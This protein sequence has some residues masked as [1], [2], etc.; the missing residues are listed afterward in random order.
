MIIPF[1]Y[2]N[3]LAWYG[4]RLAMDIFK[5]AGKPYGIELQG[6]PTSQVLPAGSSPVF[7]LSILTD[8]EYFRIFSILER[9]RIPR[10]S[11]NRD[12][13]HPV[14]VAGGAAMFQPEPLAD[15]LDVI[16]VGD[17]EEFLAGMPEI[18]SRK[19]PRPELIQ[20]LSELPGAYVPARRK[21]IYDDT[22]FFVKDMLGETAPIMG[23]TTRQWLTAPGFAKGKQHE[24]EIARGCN[25][26]CAFCAITWRNEFRER[27][28][29][30]TLKVLDGEPMD[31]F[32]P[33]TG[34]VS[35]FA[36]LL[37]LRGKGSKG[38]ITVTDFLTMPDPEP[39]AYK[40]DRYTF[41]IEGISHRL[42]RLIGKPITAEQIEEMVRRMIVG[43]AGHQQLYFIRGIPGES[44][45]DWDEL[46]NWLY[47]HAPIWRDV[48]LPTELQFTPLT[49]QAHTPL[50]YFAHP[51]NIWVEARVIKLVD[52]ARKT[53]KADPASNVYITAS[54]RATSWARDC[55]TNCTGRNGA[56]L[57]WAMHKGAFNK[58][59][60]DSYPGAG[61]TEF[62]AIVRE[63]GIDADVIFGDWPL[64]A[65]LPWSH[66][67]P[68]GGVRE[69]R[70]LQMARSLRRRLS[71]PSYQSAPGPFSDSAPAFGSS[72][73]TRFGDVAT[74]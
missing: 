23:H 19:L 18:L 26:S 10:F 73:E 36:D 14:V 24:I 3:S 29:E 63:A 65:V 41:G 58:L 70:M 2:T 47:D 55:I 44:D 59:S 64:D 67:K 33:N 68:A 13:S 56:R 39:G 43:Q 37:H 22:G 71:D 32:A 42:R 7:L 11:S 9:A 66:I 49:K 6:F 61:L 50:Q 1:V 20:A 8:R 28:E 21:V 16:C 72:Q 5:D 69:H 74:S 57:L 46:E 35:Y 45:A 31:F 54:R 48:G 62:H 38:D 53:K 27:P 51:Y 34:G 12:A 52:W 30:N 17:G 60:P 40:G 25:M 15:F 4:A